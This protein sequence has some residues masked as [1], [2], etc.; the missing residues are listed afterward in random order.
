M[1]PIEIERHAVGEEGAEALPGRAREAHMDGVVGQALVAV[2]LGD[3]AREHR[4]D[5]AVD[6]AD[7]RLDR[8]L[9]AALERR[10]RELDQA[11]VERLL[12]AVVLRS[13]MC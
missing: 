2:A 6:V 5:R 12:Q 10:L 11:V 9:L 13:R 1:S 7:R 4:A 3:V 8:H